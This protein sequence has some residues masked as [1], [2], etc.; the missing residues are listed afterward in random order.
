MKQVNDEIRKQDF[1]PS[2]NLAKLDDDL[3]FQTPMEEDLH[4]I[5]ISGSNPGEGGRFKSET[6]REVYNVTPN[7]SMENPLKS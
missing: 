1:D 3:A 7:D 5:N 4:L 6:F 2:S